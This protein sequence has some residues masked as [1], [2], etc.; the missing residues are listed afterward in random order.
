MLLKREPE[1]AS[2]LVKRLL[3]FRINFL[4]LH[5]SLTER[6]LSRGSD[7][8]M[9]MAVHEQDLFL[10]KSLFAGIPDFDVNVVPSNRLIP[11]CKYEPLFLLAV[12]YG[13]PLIDTNSFKERI[14]RDPL[15][16]KALGKSVELGF[17]A[18]DIVRAFLVHS[19]KDDPL[20][21]CAY[22]LMLRFRQ[23]FAVKCLVINEKPTASGLYSEAERFGI[24]R[25]VFA[26]LY[27]FYRRARDDRMVGRYPQRDFLQPFLR[28][29]DDYLGEVKRMTSG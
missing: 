5:G 27:E 3:G 21:G 24:N 22:S 18:L 13:L 9:L 1:L 16:R 15:D 10:A 28:A 19:D 6:K 2:E 12:K 23:A 8:D 4:V 29:T 17:S 11:S 7:V 20:W 26:K 14:L 25:Y